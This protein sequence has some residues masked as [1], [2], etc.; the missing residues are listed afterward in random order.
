MRIAQVECLP[1]RA[2]H[3]TGSRY[4]GRQRAKHEKMAVGLPERRVVG[5]AKV[6]GIVA[7]P[8]VWKRAGAAASHRRGRCFGPRTGGCRSRRPWCRAAEVLVEPSLW[9]LIRMSACAAFAISTRACRS[10]SVSTTPLPLRSLPAVF[11]RLS[12]LRVST[13]YIR[14]PQEGSQPQSDAQVHVLLDQTRSRYGPGL[15]A[16]VAGV[17][18][19]ILPPPLPVTASVGTGVEVAGTGT[20]VDVRDAAGT[21]A[22]DPV[23][24]AQQHEGMPGITT[25]GVGWASA[26]DA[27]SE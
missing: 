2:R 3:T 7:L 26:S 22:V 4:T 20:G 11:T 25:V 17:N 9:I 18:A 27:P 1:Q 14:R 21:V 19:T 5:G 16:A 6:R 15:R 23:S 24:G 13:V 10:S 12:L 8:L